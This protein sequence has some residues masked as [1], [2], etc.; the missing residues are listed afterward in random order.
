MQDADIRA[1]PGEVKFTNAS[2]S[3]A[4]IQIRPTKGGVVTLVDPV[5]IFLVL[6]GCIKFC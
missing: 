5:G 1:D 3:Q 6:I 2:L 4:N